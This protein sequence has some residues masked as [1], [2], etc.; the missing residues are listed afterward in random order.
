MIRIE[1]EWIDLVAALARADSPERVYVVGAT[2]S[3]KTTLCRYLVD[4]TA[5]HMRTA[6][7]DCDMGQ[8]RIGPPTTEGMILHSGTPAPPDRPYLRFVG[9]TSPGGHFIQTLTGAKRLVEKAAELSAGVTV[10][11]SPGLIS[12]GVGAE[13]Q[14][15]MVDLLRPTRIVALQHGREL[16][17]LLAN[18][19]RNGAMTVHRFPVSPAAVART[20]AGRR[21]YR[22]ERFRAYFADARSQDV[23]LR[24]LGLQGRV[25]DVRNPRTVEGRLVSFNDPD[26]FV[27]ALGIVEDLSPGGDRFEVF[28]P[29]FD[30][31]AV[32]SVRFGSIFLNLDANPGSMASSWR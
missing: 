8:S 22:E 27:I 13:F 18:F 1:E 12:G 3:G 7:V 5:A 20:A 19:A 24:G 9:S 2:D 30:P 32:A 14:F 21:R 26:N 11:D 23:L 16:E 6:Y 4:E 25:P 10:I 31:A 15:Q 17:R 28:A 29:P